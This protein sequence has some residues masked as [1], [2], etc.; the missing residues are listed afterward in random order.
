MSA[1]DSLS[2]QQFMYHVAQDRDRGSIE[3]GGLGGSPMLHSTLAGAQAYASTQGSHYAD[4][5]M[6]KPE[7]YRVDVGGYHTSQTSSNGAGAGMGRYTVNQGIPS[8]R[9]MRLP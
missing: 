7:V 4:G 9:I 2:P 6:A 5:T 1:F 3:N 8:G